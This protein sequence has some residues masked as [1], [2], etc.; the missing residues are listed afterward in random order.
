M[1]FLTSSGDLEQLRRVLL[2]IHDLKRPT[3][4][5]CGATGCETLGAKEVVKAFKEQFKKHD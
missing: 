4:V 2:A 3:I 5:M 1:P